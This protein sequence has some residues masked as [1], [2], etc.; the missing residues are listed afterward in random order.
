MS[1]KSL[2]DRLEVLCNPWDC[3]ASAL[4]PACAAAAEIRRLRFIADGLQMANE[5]LTR[6]VTGLRKASDV[7]KAADLLRCAEDEAG[8]LREDRQTVVRAHDA[9]LAERLAET[10]RRESAEALLRRIR[11]RN[12]L[13]AAEVNAYFARFEAT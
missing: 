6:E 13:L 12:G 9:L 2:E 3:K 4:C 7:A 5:S 1:E 8:R 10:G 11:P